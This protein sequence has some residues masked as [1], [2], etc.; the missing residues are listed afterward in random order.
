VLGEACCSSE[1]PAT[2]HGDLS[3]LLSD[4]DVN[5]AVASVKVYAVKPAAAP[6]K[7]CC[8]PSCCL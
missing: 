4:Y 6:G 2:L 3:T 1:K 8:G 7:T 5:A